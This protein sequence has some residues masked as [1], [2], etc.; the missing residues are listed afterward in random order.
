MCCSA[1]KKRMAA[2]AAA[3][4]APQSEARVAQGMSAAKC[5]LIRVAVVYTQDIFCPRY[6]FPAA[7]RI[8]SQC[9]WGMAGK[10]RNGETYH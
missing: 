6:S 3:V 7:A 4:L 10:E 2:L 1:L 8:V 9:Q 5:A